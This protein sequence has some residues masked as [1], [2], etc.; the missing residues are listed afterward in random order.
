M[1]F[2]IYFARYKLFSIGPKKSR[3]KFFKKS[4]YLPGDKIFWPDPSRIIGC[5]KPQ[6]TILKGTQGILTITVEVKRLFL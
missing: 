5:Y 3:T 1:S 6:G 2:D 4:G